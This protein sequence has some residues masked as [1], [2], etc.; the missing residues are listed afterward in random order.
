MKKFKMTLNIVTAVFAVLAC[1]A[2]L[3]I[4]YAFLTPFDRCGGWGKVDCPCYFVALFV[5]C[6]ILAAYAYW[7]W[8]LY[9]KLF[10][11][12]SFKQHLLRLAS[13]FVMFIFVIVCFYLALY[14][15]FFLSK[16]FWFYELVCS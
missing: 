12:T 4:V 3:K 10:T 6:I 2:A 8:K 13:P 9:P 16:H 11:E 15:D 14:L 7:I 1:L 5:S